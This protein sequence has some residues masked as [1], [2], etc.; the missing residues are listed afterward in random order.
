MPK[1]I[2]YIDALRG[3]TM[4][5]VVFGHICFYSFSL[6]EA[7]PLIRAIH[8]YRMPLFFFISGFIAYKG[9]EKWD[10]TYFKNQV[11]KKISIQLIPTFVIGGIYA[12]C[13][14][15]TTFGQFIADPRKL[16]YWFTISLLEML[17]IYYVISFCISRIKN[18]RKE[19]IW[20]SM[21]IL[22]SILFLLVALIIKHLNING[23]IM[24]VIDILQI[25]ETGVS[26]QYFAFGLFT[27]KYMKRIESFIFDNEK[28]L[29]GIVVLFFLLPYF[30]YE[31]IWDLATTVGLKIFRLIVSY[32]IGYI[33]IIVVFVFFRKHQIFFSSS[34]SVGHIFQFIGKRT[35]DIY[36]LHYFFLPQLPALGEYFTHISNPVL[37]LFVGILLAILVIGCCLITSSVIQTSDVLAK[38]LFGKKHI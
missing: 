6:E 25:H 5:L 23:P 7:N 28:V 8:L 34:S 29:A 4:T 37:E 15:G 10:Y 38:F 22:L 32:F 18:K 11:I 19:Q 33:G 16:G 14:I 3:F 17:I 9:I 13:F 35:L 30:L 27:S 26:F 1:R 24:T 20:D 2:E 12:Y 31:Y 21:I 36:L